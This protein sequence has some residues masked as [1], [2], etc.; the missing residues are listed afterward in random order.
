MEVFQMRI[1]RWI[2]GYRVDKRQMIVKRRPKRMKTTVEWSQ[3]E[4]V[5]RRAAD[6]QTGY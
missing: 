6:I 4:R 2:L 1:L 5:E 3:D